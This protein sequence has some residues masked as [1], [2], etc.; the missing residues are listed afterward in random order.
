[1]RAIAI[2]EFGG[3]ETL[4]SCDLPRPKPAADELLIRT[5]AA[6]VNPVD[7]KI[8]EG[9]L[10]DRLPHAFPLVPGW[11]VA[12]VVEEL[13][14]KTGRFRKG[15]RVWAYARKP[16]VQ[17]GCYAEYVAVAET[18]VAWMPGKLLY[19][20]AAAVPLAALTAWQCLFVVGDAKA[21]ASV[22]VHAAAGGV[23][24]FA[25]QL[26]HHAGC[27]VLGT[28]G[29]DNQGF[30]LELGARTAIDYTREDFREAV[31]RH[32]PEGVDLVI[33]SVDDETTDRSFE[34]L[35]P[36][37][38]L[39]SIVG[40]PDDKLAAR[41]GVRARHLFVEPSGEQLIRLRALVDQGAVRPRISKIL[42]LAEAAAAQRELA[43]GHVRGKIVLNL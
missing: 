42:G 1:M 26:A 9:L 36:G 33:A 11:D 22:L 29:P 16:V 5:V 14:E 38:V 28:A 3:P 10:R 7:W 20:E 35:K 2:H 21:G 23:G 12:G 6:G 32:R 41:H 40:V 30:L 13:G 24:H 34:V 19:E 8:R 37:G 17:W 43:G 18:S 27:E 25:V 4:H 15:D 39:V 31:R